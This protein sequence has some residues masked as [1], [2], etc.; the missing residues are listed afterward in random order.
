MTTTVSDCRQ[1]SIIWIITKCR[2]TGPPWSVGRPT[3]HAAALSPVHTGNNVEAC[4]LLRHCCWCGRGFTDDDDRR[5]QTTDDDRHQPSLLVWTPTLCVGGPVI[6]IITHQLFITRQFRRFRGANVVEDMMRV[7]RTRC[8]VI[9]TTSDISI[10]CA[11]CR[12][13]WNLSATVRPNNI[14]VFLISTILAHG[15]SAL[16]FFYGL[17]TTVF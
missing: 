14:T 1:W 15:P 16:V 12:P 10:L 11:I 3:D 17:D 9:L 4:L 7:K 13:C 6:I 8:N 5:R 2:R